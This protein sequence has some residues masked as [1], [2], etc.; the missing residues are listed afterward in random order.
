MQPIHQNRSGF[1]NAQF[2]NLLRAKAA[3]GRRS[4]CA[5]ERMADAIEAGLI[6]DSMI[7]DAIYTCQSRASTTPQV[8]YLD[9][10]AT[11]QNPAIPGGM[12]HVPASEAILSA[13][14][15]AQLGSPMLGRAGHP[16][17]EPDA[18]TL[19]VLQDAMAKAEAKAKAKAEAKAKAK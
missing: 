11:G 3:I 12:D 19:K 2:A 16:S 17:V 1:T 5:Q 4:A 15:L 9:W 8:G 7:P 6:L 13:H 14:C 10:R 18:T